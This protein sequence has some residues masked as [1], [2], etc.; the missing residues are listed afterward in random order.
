MSKTVLLVDDD[1]LIREGLARVLE[2]KGLKVIQAQN[3]EEGLR[4]ALE[5]SIDLVVTDI[6]MPKADG[7]SMLEQLRKDSKG[8]KIPAII[9]SNDDRV[10]ALN[11]ALQSGVTTYLSK[12]ILNAD[13]IAEQIIT[14]LGES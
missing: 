14:A 7:L 8:A 9:L 4:K 5:E 11:E 6:I 12:A 13:R 3:G 2:D 1:Q 10:E